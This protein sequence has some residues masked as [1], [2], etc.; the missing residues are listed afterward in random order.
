MLQRRDAIMLL[1]YAH[2]LRVTDSRSPAAPFT[3]AS[4]AT[5]HFHAGVG[6]S[7]SYTA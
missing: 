2:A 3:T 5:E 4:N 6:C 7:A 1:N